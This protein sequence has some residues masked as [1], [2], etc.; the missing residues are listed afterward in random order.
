MRQFL[1]G[2]ANPYFAPIC[3]CPQCW[4]GLCNSCCLLED[5]S[6]HLLY[7]MEQL[8][9]LSVFTKTELQLTAVVLLR[10]QLLTRYRITQRDDVSFQT[11]R[12]SDASSAWQQCEL[13]MLSMAAEQTQHAQHGSNASSACSAWQQCELS[14]LS[15]AMVSLRLCISA[16]HDMA[17]CTACL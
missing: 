3:V 7:C 5:H 10:L 16:Q 17:I 9:E 14:M 6:M 11:K 2:I 4:P 12:G 13:S 15:M 1:H 8:L